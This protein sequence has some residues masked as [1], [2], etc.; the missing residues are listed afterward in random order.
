MDPK[1][2]EPTEPVTDATEE[3]ERLAAVERRRAALGR[4][5]YIEREGD[6]DR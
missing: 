4:P 2:D 1:T 3:L 5:D 6:D